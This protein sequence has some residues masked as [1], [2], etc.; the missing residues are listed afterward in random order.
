MQPC[1][2][3]ACLRA[4]ALH[5]VTDEAHLPS[6]HGRVICR[7]LISANGSFLHKFYRAGRWEASHTH[8]SWVFLPQASFLP[9]VWNWLLCY[10]VPCTRTANSPYYSEM[11]CKQRSVLTCSNTS[12]LCHPPGRHRY[13]IS[14]TEPTKPHVLLVPAVNVTLL[15]DNGA[16]S[17]NRGRE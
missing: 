15:S 6:F 9:L 14:A 5:K 2:L 4:H 10:Q 13:P 16:W 3:E 7:T 17:Q 8:S 11:D 12:Y 1:L